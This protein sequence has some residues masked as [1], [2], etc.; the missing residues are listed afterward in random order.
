MVGLFRLFVITAGND[1]SDEPLTK[2][3]NEKLE[4]PE[5]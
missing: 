1:A 4:N 2:N 3:V 5:Q